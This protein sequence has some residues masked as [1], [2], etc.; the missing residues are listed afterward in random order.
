M[1]KDIVSHSTEGT[2]GSNEEDHEGNMREQKLSNGDERNLDTKETVLESQVDLQPDSSPCMPPDSNEL[3]VQNEHEV[4]ENQ[5]STPSKSLVN[6]TEE[7]QGDLKNENTEDNVIAPGN[8][9]PACSNQVVVD[10]KS[11]SAPSIPSG[12][13]ELSLQNCNESNKN[14]QSPPSSRNVTSSDDGQVSTKNEDAAPACSQHVEDEI[15]VVEQRVG[16]PAS[17][18]SDAQIE[19]GPVTGMYIIDAW[20]IPGVTNKVIYFEP[21]SKT[22]QQESNIVFFPGDVQDLEDIML[23]KPQ[24]TPYAQHSLENTARILQERNPCA[25]LFVIRAAQLLNG[26]YASYENFVLSSAK[27]MGAAI[28]YDPNG[29]ACKHLLG[30]LKYCEDAIRK[31]TGTDPQLHLPLELVGFSKGVLPLNQLVTELAT[32]ETSRPRSSSGLS[33]PRTER[34]PFPDVDEHTEFRRPNSADSA[35]SPRTARQRDSIKERLEKFD[36]LEANLA[37]AQQNLEEDQKR[38]AESVQIGNSML[39][40]VINGKIPQ[41]D[42]TGTPT[43]PNTSPKPPPLK[44]PRPRSSRSRGKSS[45][46]SPNSGVSPPPIQSIFQQQRSPIRRASRRTTPRRQGSGVGDAGSVHSTPKP[47]WNGGSTTGPKTLQSQL[48]GSSVDLLADLAPKVV[49]AR[50]RTRSDKFFQE[51]FALGDATPSAVPQETH[52]AHVL[53]SQVSIIQWLDGGN[54]GLKESLPTSELAVRGLG[55]L[56]V[57]VG[58]HGTPWQWHDIRRPWLQEEAEA[59]VQLLDRMCVPYRRRE[60]FSDMAPALKNHFAILTVYETNPFDKPD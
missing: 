2:R 34:S 54:A 32:W 52:P 44:I 40:E 57:K 56:K 12:P 15:I 42:G 50:R 38:Y 43:D 41:T 24:T 4:S 36:E 47:A 16:S 19:N 53:F 60:Y 10:T 27:D 29:T 11:E 1:S 9:A 39:K 23:S 33:T 13:S 17:D 35:T 31:Y 5:P 25:G 30:L 22:K 49:S 18:D 28:R 21:L 6:T 46:L 26:I 55:T 59:F 7:G 58:F 48:S 37:L 3:F 8:G 51:A 20:G 14:Q 45:I